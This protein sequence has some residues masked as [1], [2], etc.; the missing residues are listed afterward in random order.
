MFNEVA[1]SKV[2]EN[3]KNTFCYATFW[4]LAM[5]QIK[6]KLTNDG[7]VFRLSQKR[8]RRLVVCHKVGQWQ[9]FHLV[10]RVDITV[11]TFNVFLHCRE[12]TQ[13]NLL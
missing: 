10:F 13:L 12:I 2:V 7:L 11:K 4:F 1:T 3:L 6:F 8:V 5:L 9:L